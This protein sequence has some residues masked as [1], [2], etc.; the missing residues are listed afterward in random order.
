MREM[1]G[2][3]AAISGAG[4]GESVLLLTDGRFSGATRGLSVGHI[5]PEASRGGPIA[6]I[7]EGDMIALNVAKRTL[8]VDLSDT[9]I[10]ARMAAWQAPAPRYKTGVM[11]KYARMVSSASIGAITG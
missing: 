10:T 4:L 3:T 11:A 5:S 1:L 2:V 9:E 6:A 8:D 7:R